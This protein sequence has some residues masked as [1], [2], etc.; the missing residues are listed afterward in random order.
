MILQYH[1][2]IYV[3]LVLSRRK[4]VPFIGDLNELYEE[5]ERLREE[6]DLAEAQILAIKRQKEQDK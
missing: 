4:P 3:K 6:E 5:R 2:E 1:K